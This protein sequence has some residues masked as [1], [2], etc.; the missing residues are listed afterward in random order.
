MRCKIVKP[1]KLMWCNIMRS[2]KRKKKVSV[3]QYSIDMN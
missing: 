1:Q 3:L 2:I